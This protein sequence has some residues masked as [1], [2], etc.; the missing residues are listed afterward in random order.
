MK[1]I[2]WNHRRTELDTTGLYW[3]KQ[4]TQC[5]IPAHTKAAMCRTASYK[6]VKRLYEDDQLFDL[7]NDPGETKNLIHD[8][9]YRLEIAEHKALLSDWYMATCDVVPHQGDSR[10]MMYGR[11]TF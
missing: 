10:R 3:P 4:A 6:Y 1:G 9:D 2:A 7:T 5:E 11:R 8:E